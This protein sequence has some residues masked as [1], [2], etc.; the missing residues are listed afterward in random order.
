M[1][2]SF[3]TDATAASRLRVEKNPTDGKYRAVIQATDEAVKRAGPG[4][5]GRAFNP[6]NRAALQSVIA[7]FSP[8]FQGLGIR[9][10]FHDSWEY[11]SNGCP[12]LF[13]RFRAWREYDLQEHLAA[14]AG[15][16][17]PEQVARVR[18][19]VQRTLADLAL[20]DFIL[21]WSEWCHELG[22]LSRNQAH[23]SPGNLLDLYAA[24]DIPETEC[25]RDVTE[26]TPLLSKFASSAAH[27]SGKRLVSSETG[28]W[29]KEH[30][31]TTLGDLKNLID[32]LFTAG[33]NHHV[34]H[35]T[36]YSPPEVDWPGW[37]FYASAQL[38][39]QNSIWRD[40]DQLNAYVT[41]CQSILQH[42]QHANDLLVYF[43]LH[44]IL[45]DSSR[46]LAEELTI[47]GRWMGKLRAA[48]TFR[49]LWRRGFQ[50]DYISDLQIRDLQEETR[51]LRAP[52][53][54]YRALLIP[55]CHYL[56]IETLERLVEL[57]NQGATILFQ[58]PAP[59]DVPGMT[60]LESRRPRFHELIQKMEIIDNWEESLCQRGIHREAMTDTGLVCV[61]R[62]HARGYDYFIVNQ[63]GESVAAWIP[64]S[65]PFAAVLL[66]DP[67]TGMTG[68][69]R[70]RNGKPLEVYIQMQ[71]GE[72]LV[73][74]TSNT[75]EVQAETEWPYLDETPRWQNL[76]GTWNV[77]FMDGGPV[78]PPS[79]QSDTLTSWTDRGGEAARFAGTAC[80][81]LQFDAPGPAKSWLLDLGL[82][83]DSARIRLNGDECAVRIGPSFRTVLH[84][85]NP[86]A[87]LL[88]I[89]VTN[90]AANRIRDLD[91]RK[92]EWK[93]FED[94]NFVNRDYQPFDASTW[95]LSPSG[96]LGPVRIA[97]LEK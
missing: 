55:P 25:F 49:S 94:I 81:S 42:G 76:S 89:E 9:A 27:V 92:V 36:C 66:M 16:G 47:E 84:Q 56:P 97:P 7:H 14:L 72:S 62:Q 29:L 79:F 45:H 69:A 78:L 75:T 30:F 21:P 2:G 22:H 8:H 13:E 1:G 57:S 82:V 60:Q 65:V 86:R 83:H 74:R 68:T 10:Q 93:I 40:F 54:L 37:L 71:A 5:T 43:P 50:F 35:G 77:V 11:E 70:I 85:L 33:I 4:G 44:D 80:Y 26:D 17:D 12:Q 67:M 61:R 3:I 63:G 91:R 52:G 32:V 88:E 58:A 95:P 34:Y 28:T 38:N 41:R 6:F 24:A 15:E 18:Y 73:L 87:N 90:L 51:S 64:L 31:Q 96:L 19:D 20:H 23:G 53:G 59:F 46:K 48:D 39:P